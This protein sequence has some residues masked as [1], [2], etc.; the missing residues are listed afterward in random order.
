M[1][2]GSNYLGNGRCKFTV[3][4]PFPEEISVQTFSPNNRLIP[5]EKDDWG[6]FKVLPK[7]LAP[8]TLYYY[9]LLGEK[10]IP[11]PTSHSQPNELD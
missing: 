7:D 8:G 11:E 10:D 2:I 1:E 4:A 6:Y 5:M 9:K 3:W